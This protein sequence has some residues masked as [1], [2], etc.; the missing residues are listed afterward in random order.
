MARKVICVSL[1]P[2]QIAFLDE[3]K[4]IS[5]SLLLQGEINKLRERY[6]PEKLN[7]LL[8][9]ISDLKHN[10]GKWRDMFFTAQDILREN[11]L[12]DELQR[13]LPIK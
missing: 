2:E 11:G 4:D 6:N 1:T 10:I 12:F 3:N 7:E 13:K 5:P 9:E 8:E